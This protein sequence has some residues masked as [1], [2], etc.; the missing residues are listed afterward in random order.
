[1]HFLCF[2]VFPKASTH[3][4]GIRFAVAHANREQGV[5]IWPAVCAGSAYM[6]S[7]LAFEDLGPTWAQL[8]SLSLIAIW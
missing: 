4:T 6:G 5:S 2:P 1:M 8:I 3:R 7:Q